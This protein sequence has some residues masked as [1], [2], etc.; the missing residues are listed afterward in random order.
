M[1]NIERFGSYFAIPALVV[2]AVATSSTQDPQGKTD[3][4]KGS[5]GEKGVAQSRADQDL[6]A[7]MKAFATPGAAHAVLEPLAGTWQ[8]EMKCFAPEGPQTSSGTSTV[9]W[10]L[11]KHFLEDRLE[12]TWMGKP[13]HGLG[14]VGYDNLKKK[15]VLVW[16]DD[17]GTGAMACEGDYDASTKTFNYVG[18]MPDVR[19]GRYA[20]GRLVEKIVDDKHFTLQMYGPGPDGSEMLTMQCDY[21][22]K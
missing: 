3:K 20:R 17:Q 1:H 16:L 2:L 10:V 6:E 14:H 11:D 4:A 21:R 15:Y 5:S 7:K 22:K 18:E 19:A 13:F 12:A 9:S 8:V